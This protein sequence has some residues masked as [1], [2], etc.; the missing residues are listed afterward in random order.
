MLISI[1][2]PIKIKKTRITMNAPST[3]ESS[4]NTNSELASWAR[5]RSREEL[6]SFLDTREA[7]CDVADFDL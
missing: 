5:E 3:I 4:V 1:H 6:R 2:N 7:A